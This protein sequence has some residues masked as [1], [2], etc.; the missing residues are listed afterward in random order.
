VPAVRSLR[1]AAVALALVAAACDGDGGATTGPEAF[2]ERLRDAQAELVPVTDPASARATA[3]RFASLSDAAPEEIRPEW[4]QLTELFRTVA[5]LDPTD[6]TFRDTVLAETG[7][8]I[9]AAAE[10]NAWVQ[11]RCGLDLTAAS[12][13]P[14]TPPTSAPPGATSPTSAAPGATTVPSTT[15]GGTVPVVPVETSPP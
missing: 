1:S 8:T 9:T 11:Q 3:D 13:T 4:D 5:A 12:L 6:P 15:A 7:R 10:V 14:L 2:C